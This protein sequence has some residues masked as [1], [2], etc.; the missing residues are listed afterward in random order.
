LR[1]FVMLS[2]KCLTVQSRAFSWIAT[3][4]T[5]SSYPRLTSVRLPRRRDSPWCFGTASAYFWRLIVGQNC[6]PLR[7]LLKCQTAAAQADERHCE[8]GRGV[9][10][11]RF[12][13]LAMYR[14]SG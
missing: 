2:A 7:E 11:G 13:D 3:R 14:V 9:P 12:T 4:S 6:R 10:A 8:R 1:S 5:M